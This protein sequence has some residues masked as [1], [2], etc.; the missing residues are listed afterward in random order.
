MKVLHTYV[1][2]FTPLAHSL[3]SSFFLTKQSPSTVFLVCC[4]PDFKENF[5]KLFP[6]WHVLIQPLNRF[7]LCNLPLFLPNIHTIHKKA[8]RSGNE[9][10]S[11]KPLTFGLQLD[12]LN[13][14][15]EVLLGHT[16]TPHCTCLSVST[17]NTFHILE[18]VQNLLGLLF[19][20]SF[21][22][23]GNRKLNLCLCF[24]NP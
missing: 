21:Y 22:F 2:V 13:V 3:F 16:F 14:L 1:S 23:L 20:L 19:N 7:F 24:I 10:I 6:S 5:S 11:R 18:F 12:V 9:T 4:H 8:I 17:V 15:P